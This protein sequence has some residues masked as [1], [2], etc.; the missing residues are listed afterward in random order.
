MRNTDSSSLINV[1]QASSA[2]CSTSD[3]LLVGP[4]MKLT[5]QLKRELIPVCHL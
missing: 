1:T 5:S 3:I 4:A 2:S